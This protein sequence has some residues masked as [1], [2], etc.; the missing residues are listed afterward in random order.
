M[1]NLYDDM[2]L[3]SIRPPIETWLEESADRELGE[4][5]RALATRSGHLGALIAAGALSRYERFIYSDQ[6]RE[7]FFLD[8][9]NGVL[10]EEDAQRAWSRELPSAEVEELVAYALVLCAWLEDELERAVRSPIHGEILWP[11]V[12]QLRDD[13]ESLHALLSV[14]HVQHVLRERLEPLDRRAR[15]SFQNHRASS[16]AT[17]VR[18]MRASIQYPEAWWTGGYEELEPRQF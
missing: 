15:Q 18:L 2:H 14:H 3:P 6:E 1:T 17:S 4:E 10:P 5:L 8:L 7:A 13:I 16:A 9:A 12:R 11:G